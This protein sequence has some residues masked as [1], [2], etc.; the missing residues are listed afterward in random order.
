MNEK[1]VQT[2]QTCVYELGYV[3]SDDQIQKLDIYYHYLIQRNNHVNLTNIIDPDEV[4]V[5]HFADSLTCFQMDIKDNDQVIDVGSGAGFPGM[6][7]K[8]FNH[9]LSVTMLDSLQKRVDFLN[10]LATKLELSDIVAVHGRAEEVGK[11]DNHRE[12]Y[13]VVVSR[14]V[15]NLATLAEYCLPFVK[16]GGS[17]IAMKGPKAAEEIATASRAVQILGGQIAQIKEFKLPITGDERT[18]IKISKIN[19]TP[20]KYPRKAGTPAKK[21]IK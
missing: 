8:I 18:L 16:L 15:A 3:L 6:V 1:L 17:F 11:V 19:P 10:N 21:P 13:D 12:H 9:T 2:L 20:A 4:A 5:K 7:L 14:A